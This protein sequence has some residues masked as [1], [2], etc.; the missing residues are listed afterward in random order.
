MLF[1]SLAFGVFLLTVLAGYFLLRKHYQG[2]N[3][4]LLAASLVSYG[5]W[6]ARFLSLLA[7]SIVVNFMAGRA[8]HRTAILP[9]RRF[10]LGLALVWN[11]AML[12]I[13]KYFN[14]FAAGLA[15][16]MS[17]FGLEADP[18]TLTMILPLGLSFYTFQ[19][20][21]YPFDIY[22]GR[23]EPTRNLAEFALFVSFFPTVVSGPIE[24]ASHLLPQITAPR[25]VS[26]EDFNEGLTLI[27]WGYFQKLVIADNLALLVNRIY[28]N[29][30]QYQGLDIGL[31]ILAYTIQILADFAGYTDIARGVARLLGF[32]LPLNFNLPYF[33]TSPSDFWNRWHMSLS[34]WLRDYLYIPLGGNRKGKARTCLNLLLTMG[35]CGLWHGA[36]LTFIIWGLFHGALLAIQRLFARGKNSPSTSRWLTIMK[37]LG[38]FCLVAAGWAIFR[39]SSLGQMG[40]LFSHLGISW[41]AETAEILGRLV[42]FSWPLVVLQII[43]ARTVNPAPIAWLNPWLR[44]LVYAVLIAG[45]FVFSTRENV[46]FIY[47]GF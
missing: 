40:Y 12:G 18:I 9:R 47:Q 16:L 34:G 28:G 29:Y 14:F 6:D 2:Q 31:G 24:R 30:T 35:L 17:I 41:S 3:A 19:A 43:Q 44:G 1:N 11:L 42:F 45:C 46:R 36:A 37:T 5:A 20:I 38:M 10:W 32:Q 26:A 27:A 23:L 13:F 8:I 25:R 7:A 4:L 39:S 21:S 33:A 15:D 22:R